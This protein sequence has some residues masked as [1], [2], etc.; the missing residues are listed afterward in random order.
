MSFLY[1]LLFLGA[2]VVIHELGHFTA[3][4]LLDFKVVSFTIGFGRRLVRIRSRETVYQIGLIPL[5]GF[6]Q[7]LGEESDAPAHS[8]PHLGKLTFKSCP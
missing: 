7:I 2:L 8:H 1:F 5:G 6:V 3:A 4:K